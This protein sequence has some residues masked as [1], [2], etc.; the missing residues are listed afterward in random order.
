MSTPLNFNLQSDQSAVQSDSKPSVRPN[1]LTL[2]DTTDTDTV[3]KT[4]I[5]RIAG[6]TGST[7]KNPDNPLMIPLIYTVT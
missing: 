1:A 2:S 7:G 4:I 6:V 5:F 3:A